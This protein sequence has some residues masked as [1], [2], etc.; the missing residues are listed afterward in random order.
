MKARISY[1]LK[2]YAKDL[3]ILMVL[4]VLG[5]FIDNW[6]GILS[7]INDQIPGDTLD[8]PAWAAAA[9]LALVVN[10][11]RELKPSSTDAGTANTP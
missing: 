4:L 11:R 10:L 2:Q 3:G 1:R 5:F 9:G 8:I 6:T 7:A